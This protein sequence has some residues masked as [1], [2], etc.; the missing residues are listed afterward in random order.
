MIEQKQRKFDFPNFI[1]ARRKDVKKLFLLLLMCLFVC[2]FAVGCAKEDSAT[3]SGLVFEKAGD[4]YY[5]KDYIGSAT[6]V[7]IPS[8][9]KGLPI[10]SIGDHAFWVCSSLT[11]ITF[12]GTV[13]QWN[14][15]SKGS[16]WNDYVPVTEVICEG[17]SVS[18]K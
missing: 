1:D 5:V 7:D 18:L 15:I 3:A 16:D 11:S 14:A 17:G 10:T 13:D 9:Y 2:M 6:T 12:Q 4:T 8:K